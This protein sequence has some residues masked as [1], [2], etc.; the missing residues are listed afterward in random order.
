ML[1]FIDESGCPG[2]KFDRGSSAVFGLGMVIFRNADEATQTQEAIATVRARLNHKVEFKFS[3]SRDE[4]R[5]AFFAAVARCPFSVRALVVHKARLYSRELTNK[6]DRFYN[7]F[8][9]TLM[10]FDGGTLSAAKVRI[11]GSGNREFQNELSAYLRRQ[12]GGRVGEVRVSDSAKDP[13]M[14]LADMCIGAITRAERID[15]ADCDR[16]KRMLE[17]RID[18]V[19]AFG[20]TK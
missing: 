3:R 12:L 9:K 17:P 11:D 5:D 16:W 18:D 1:V 10:K 19:F 2:F 4:V 15:R 13:L 8:V 6:T 20:T 7:Y 14:Q